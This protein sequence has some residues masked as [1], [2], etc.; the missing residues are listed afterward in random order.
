M[1]LLC[2]ISVNAFH[3]YCFQL[4]DKKIKRFVEKIMQF[5]ICVYYWKTNSNGLYLVS[6]G[7]FLGLF[8]P[9]HFPL[10]AVGCSCEIERFYIVE[11]YPAS[12]QNVGGFTLLP[13]CA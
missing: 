9:N 5:F 12:L 7:G 8:T 13:V 1:S 10:T 3:I 6:G 11:S 4:I 2:I